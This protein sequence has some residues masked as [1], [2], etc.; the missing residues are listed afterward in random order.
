MDGSDEVSLDV[1]RGLAYIASRPEISNVL[2]T[3]GDPLT[4]ST[5]RIAAIL[6]ALREID[7][8]RIIRLGTKI[9]A[10]N[11]DRIVRDAALRDVIRAHS[12]PDR[13]I[14][15]IVHFDHPRERTPQAID[16]IAALQD[17]GAVCANQTP[18]LRGI[19]DDAGALATLFETVAR[20][21]CPQYYVFQGR[22]IAGNKSFCVPVVR[23]YQLF[24]AASRA[25]SGLAGRARFVL[26]HEQGKLEIVGLDASSIYAR[27]HRARDPARH[28][29]FFAV[30]RDEA[31][32]WL[33]PPS[34]PGP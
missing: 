13:R 18:L 21:G 11:P 30:P 29:E 14:H 4:M 32:Y 25:V 17:A 5:G 7:H 9:P 8:V 12:G 15:A 16:C 26:S 27:F 33:D 28:G 24:Q 20:A 2:L 23:A 22:P 34:R 31:A 10:F 1:S 19:N 6:A 3:G